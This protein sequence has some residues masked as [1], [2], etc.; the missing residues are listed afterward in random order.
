MTQNASTTSRYVAAA[1]I[2]K[3][4]DTHARLSA[5]HTEVPDATADTGADGAPSTPSVCSSCAQAWPCDTAHALD[6]TRTLRAEIHHLLNPAIGILRLSAHQAETSFD[7]LAV[8]I[9]A[10]PHTAVNLSARRLIATTRALQ[11][12]TDAA[13]FALGETTLREAIATVRAGLSS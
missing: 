2:S 3:A 6:I 4:G 8:D 13:D 1:A 5:E 9:A 7:P 10:A 11:S 12:A